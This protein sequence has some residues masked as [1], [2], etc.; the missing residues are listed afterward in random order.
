ME[1]QAKNAG[2]SL[3]P[4]D[5]ELLAQRARVRTGGNRS[6]YVRIAVRE[7]AERSQPLIDSAL[8]KLSPEE[9]RVLGYSTANRT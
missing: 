9:A 5:R 7:E 4:A 3:R 8:S 6:A 1:E 2:I